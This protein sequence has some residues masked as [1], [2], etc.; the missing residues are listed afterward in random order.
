[1]TAQHAADPPATPDVGSDVGV[2]RLPPEV[3]L[4]T[5]PGVRDELMA[6]LN[7]CAHLVVDATGVEFMDSSGVNALV[8]AKERADRLDGTL[9]VVATGRAVVRVLALTQLTRVLGVVPD[10][11]AARRCVD[12]PEPGHTCQ[13]Q[14]E[15]A[16]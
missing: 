8:R 1:M 5:A 6:S 14:A 16:R 2:V 3:D 11:E 15:E 13:E 12:G 7:R 9:H 10:P 4:Q